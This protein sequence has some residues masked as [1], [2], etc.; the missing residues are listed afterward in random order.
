[1]TEYIIHTEAGRYM[2]Y[3]AETPE[4]AERYASYDKHIPV[5]TLTWE[6]HERWVAQHLYKREMPPQEAAYAIFTERRAS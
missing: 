5:L 6:Q 1:M 4:D 2:S 3:H